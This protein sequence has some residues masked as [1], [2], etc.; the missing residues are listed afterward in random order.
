MVKT[1]DKAMEQQSLKIILENYIRDRA[2][3][4]IHGGTLER[5]GQHYGFEGETAKRT[6]RKTVNE[7]ENIKKGFSKGCVCYKWINS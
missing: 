3:S 1:K 4:W 2:G 6:M 5:V 7:N